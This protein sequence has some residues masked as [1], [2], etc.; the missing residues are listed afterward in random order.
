VRL[1]TI[2]GSTCL[3]LLCG[4]AALG[5]SQNQ[6]QTPPPATVPGAA[7]AGRAGGRGGPAVVSPQIEPDGRVTFRIS[8]PQ[9]AMV[10]VGGD[11]GGSLVPD[12]AA[13]PAPAAPPSAA[14]A[15]PGARG[16]GRG[17][18]PPVTM[19]K[20]EVAPKLFR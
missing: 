11:V 14:P 17:G 9:A 4:I 6:G 8:A 18:P 2:L 1:H 16:G 15:A 3:V 5:Q 7:G 19:V 13:P 12:P 20:G 10:T